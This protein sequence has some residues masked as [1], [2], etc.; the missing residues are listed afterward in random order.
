MLASDPITSLTLTPAEMAERDLYVATEVR[1]RG[2]PMA[3]TLSGGYGPESWQAHA[4]AITG[5]VRHFEH[6]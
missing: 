5:L 4:Q 1:R 2:I 3:V 6:S